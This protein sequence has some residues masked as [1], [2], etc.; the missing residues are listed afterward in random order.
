MIEQQCDSDDCIKVADYFDVYKYHGNNSRFDKGRLI[1]RIKAY[2]WHDVMKYVK[3]LL[4][5]KSTNPNINCEKDFAFIEVKAQ[6]T[7]TNDDNKGGG[8]IILSGY[9]TYLNK[10]GDESPK[11]QNCWDLTV[12][13]R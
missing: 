10:E 3:N 8:E 6:S 7:P 12:S 13:S 11:D 4:L 5:N 2:V 9:K 1:G